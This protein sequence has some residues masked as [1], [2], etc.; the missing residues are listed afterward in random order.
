ML[1]DVLALLLCSF[2]LIGRR[3]VIARWTALLPGNTRCATLLPQQR[4]MQEPTPPRV[5]IRRQWT[6]NRSTP[7][8]RRGLRAQ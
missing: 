4:E 6:L 2:H 8:I 3:Q 7:Q 1:D 5:F